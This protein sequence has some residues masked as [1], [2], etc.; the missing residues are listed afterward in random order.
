M[1]DHVFSDKYGQKFFSIMDCKRKSHKFRKNSRPARPRLYYFSAH[2]FRCLLHFLQ[3]MFIDERSLFQRSRQSWS[4]C[5]EIRFSITSR[6]SR[7][8]N[9]A[10]LKS[11][12][13]IFPAHSSCPGARIPER[14]Y[15]L[16]LLTIS[17]SV[18]F[19][20]RVL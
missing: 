4:S 20:V 19:R 1:S 13:L 16:R 5:F 15:L 18:A 10:C 12:S 8:N 14:S 11:M 9:P 17:L 3:Q 6:E 2:R 7:V